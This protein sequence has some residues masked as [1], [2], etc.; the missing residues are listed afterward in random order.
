[1]LR[2]Q[3]RPGVKRK[4]ERVGDVKICWGFLCQVGNI[5]PGQQL[6]Y[7][8]RTDGCRLRFAYQIYVFYA[9]FSLCRG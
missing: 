9:L 5:A 7:E 8:V 3:H 4:H 6:T 2:R 1:M